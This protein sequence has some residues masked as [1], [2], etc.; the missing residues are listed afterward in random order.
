MWWGRCLGPR[1]NGLENSLRCRNLL[2]EIH[3]CWPVIQRVEFNSISL[4]IVH[5]QFVPQRNS[6]NNSVLGRSAY[7]TTL[8][9]K[10]KGKAL[11]LNAPSVLRHDLTD[12][13]P[14]IDCNTLF[15]QRISNRDDVEKLLCRLIG[16]VGGNALGVLCFRM[17]S[18]AFPYVL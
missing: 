12:E 13:P 3:P 10:G 11:K 17:K 7:L 14:S 15:F 9:K 8:C 18:L 6:T 2:A 5:A 1:T 16:H 4:R